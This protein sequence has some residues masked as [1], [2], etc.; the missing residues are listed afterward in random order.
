M[1]STGTDFGGV[2]DATDAAALYTGTNKADTMVIDVTGFY[3]TD[4][5]EVDYTTLDG[6]A[7]HD[8]LTIRL[9]TSQMEALKLELASQSGVFLN[10][11]GELI[12]DA[13]SA[14]TAI[15]TRRWIRSA[16]R[17]SRGKPSSL[18]SARTRS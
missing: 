1:A 17:S 12:G 5:A 13:Q 15:S 10:D 11:K 16:S 18:R 7:N 9:T 3:G 6:G 8:S 4:I 2:V 14:S